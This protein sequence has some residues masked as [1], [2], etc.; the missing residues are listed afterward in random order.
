Y[1][2]VCYCPEPEKGS[3]RL[4]CVPILFANNTSSTAAK[5]EIRICSVDITYTE[6]YNIACQKLCEK[7]GMRKEG[8]FREF[9]SFANGE[10]GKPIYENTYQ[11]AILK[12][13]WIQE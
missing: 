4:F 5:F 11:Y 1:R 7:L 13:E 8:L 6:D 10:D 9:V 2:Y 12:S 3:L